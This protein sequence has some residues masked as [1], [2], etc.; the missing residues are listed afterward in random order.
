MEGGKK[1]YMVE[2]FEADITFRLALSLTS[3]PWTVSFSFARI[4]H[5]IQTLRIKNTNLF[6]HIN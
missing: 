2:L 5:G 6:F 1:G 4:Y 3:T